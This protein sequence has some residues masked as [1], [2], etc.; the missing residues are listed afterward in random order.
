MVQP[1]RLTGRSHQFL[2]VY[3]KHIHKKFWCKSTRFKKWA[4]DDA[5]LKKLGGGDKFKL[6]KSQ[7]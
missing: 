5:S 3:V 6:R 1:G 7:S 2:L 4:G